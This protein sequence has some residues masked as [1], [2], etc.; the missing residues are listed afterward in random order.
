[1]LVV[2]DVFML[3]AVFEEIWPWPVRTDSKPTIVGPVDA[4]DGYDA[5][6]Q[7]A[8]AR[9]ERFDGHGYEAN[10]RHDYW[11]GRKERADILHRYVIKAS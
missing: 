9:A 6:R 7:L 11:W 1:M 10:A 4:A 2:G 8:K 5:A 3:V